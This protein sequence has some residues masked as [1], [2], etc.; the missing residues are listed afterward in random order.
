MMKAL[1]DIRGF[2]NRAHVFRCVLYNFWAHESSD[3]FGIWERERRGKKSVVLIEEQS[4]RG[5]AVHNLWFIPPHIRHHYLY[6]ALLIQQIQ[7]SHLRLNKVDAWLIVIEI[8]K[9]PGNLL[10]QVFFLF[11]FKH[12]LQ[13]ERS[14]VSTEAFSMR[15]LWTIRAFTQQIHCNSWQGLILHWT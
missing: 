14:E 2:S 4:N 9:C 6:L 7:Y 10:L 8:Y 3:P 13:R 12:M 11:Q 5:Q 1:L 15:Q